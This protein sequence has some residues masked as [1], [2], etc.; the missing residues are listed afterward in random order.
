[1]SA[2]LVDTV[3]KAYTAGIPEDVIL[4]FVEIFPV[5]TGEAFGA[6]ITEAD[7]CV[8]SELIWV[9]VGSLNTLVVAIIFNYTIFKKL[10]KN[11]QIQNA[12]IRQ[13]SISNQHLITP[14]YM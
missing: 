6:Y 1:L 2:I 4:P 14:L 9:L 3:E 12:K 8:K 10:A 13:N 5:N 7:A 11:P